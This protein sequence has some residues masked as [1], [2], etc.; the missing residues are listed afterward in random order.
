MKHPENIEQLLTIRPDFMGLIFYPKSPRNVDLNLDPEFIQSLKDVK[1]VGVFVNESLD[2]IGQ[3]I[4]LYGLDMIQLHGQESPE[5]CRHLQAEQV[6]VVKVFSVG[7]G[8][9]FGCLR[10]YESVVDYFLFD[11]K[12]KHP[13]GNG[14][15]FNWEI[16]QEYPSEHPFFLSGGIGPESLD[17]LKTLNFP[18]LYAID[19]NSRFELD[20]GLKDIPAVQQFAL[21]LTEISN[22]GTS[23]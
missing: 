1:K 17:R 22:P 12:G 23:L 3:K 11:T 15:L 21:Q 19:V 8:F 18:K 9:D 10:P 2:T 14:L 20:P 5:T 13:G 6:E 4:Q 7:N 16:L